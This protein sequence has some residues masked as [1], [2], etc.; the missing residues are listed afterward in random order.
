MDEFISMVTSQLGI[1]EEASRSATG[2][3]L[4]MVKEQLDDST[5][6]ALLD[7]IPGADALIGEADEAGESSASGGGGLM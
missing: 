5:F 4:K 6:G 2:G 1:G 7:K 3:I